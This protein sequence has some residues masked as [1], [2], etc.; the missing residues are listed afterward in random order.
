MS[1]QSLDTSSLVGYES[2]LEHFKTLYQ[3]RKLPSFLLFYGKEGIGKNLF[4][5]RLCA[6]L[7]CETKRACGQCAS[8]VAFLQNR[9]PSVY[10]VDNKESLISVEE[11]S[12]IKAHLFTSS[13]KEGVPRVVCIRDAE[14]LSERSTN[15]L[16]T[17]LEDLPSNSYIFLTTGRRSSLLPTL[18]SRAVSFL[19]K[20]LSYERAFKIVREKLSEENFV[21]TKDLEDRVS[22]LLMEMKGSIG[23]VL[24]VLKGG[25]SSF[26]ELSDIF[27]EHILKS[28]YLLLYE[29]VEKIKKD[30][31]I[32]LEDCLIAIEIAINKAY[33]NLLLKTSS[34][35]QKKVSLLDKKRK[36]LVLLKKHVIDKK[37]K[38]NKGLALEGLLLS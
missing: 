9:H 32:P 8:C 6:Y 31:S 16:L 18:L 5:L 26:W 2:E 23:G 28:D 38:L 34:F 15:K 27:Y 33:K 11:T 12:R 14:R 13:V 36:T 4:A 24:S 19:L 30:K 37:I 29:L 17:S 22:L 10:F 35:S 25:E 1:Q 3:E 20:P 7:V 21:V